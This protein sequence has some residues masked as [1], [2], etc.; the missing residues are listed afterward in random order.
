MK[1][2]LLAALLFSQDQEKLRQ[3][4]EEARRELAA[5]KKRIATEEAAQEKELQELIEERNRL[6]DRRVDLRLSKG[7]KAKEFETLR[8][9]RSALREEV[10][11]AEEDLAEAERILTESRRQIEDMIQVLPP[12]ETVRDADVGSIPQLLA[13]LASILE[14]GSSTALYKKKVRT[15]RGTEELAEILRV[16]QI[17]WAYRTTTDRIALA[18]KSPAGE[19]G[20]RWKEDLPSSLRGRIEAAMGATGMVPMPIDVTQQ[21]ASESITRRETAADTLLAGGP[22]MIPLGIVALLALLLIIERAHFLSREGRRTR[23]TAETVLALSGEAKF[24]EA[25]KACKERSGPVARA[26]Q[27]CLDRRTQGTDAME[28]G[29]Q[30]AVLHEMPRLERFLST[31]GILAG[32]A[33]LLGLLGTV[34]G[35][36]ITFDMITVFGTGDPRIMAGGISQ[37]LITTATGLVIAIPVLL[38]HSFL[39]ARVDRLIADTE[40]YAAS[41]LNLLKERS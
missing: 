3:A 23:K 10:A 39:A 26:L 35:M 17:A 40:R 38:A 25:S 8:E 31:I 5:E 1:L 15:P 27:A 19:E 9:K 18:M 13:V 20:F 6:S 21:M 24:D 29:V 16:G 32:V 2:L 22:V 14:E 41:L 34:T 4:V 28:D 37:A 30:E 11:E 12:G 7:E 33:P 36:I